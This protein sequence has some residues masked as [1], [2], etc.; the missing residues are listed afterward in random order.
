MSAYTRARKYDSVVFKDSSGKKVTGVALEFRSSYMLVGVQRTDK[1]YVVM[2][3]RKKDGTPITTRVPNN[4]IWSV[5]YECVL[6][7]AMSANVG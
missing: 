6:E 1:P 7:T 5:P 4:S 3:T 2:N